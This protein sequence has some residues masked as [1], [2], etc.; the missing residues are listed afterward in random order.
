M[1]YP[2]YNDLEGYCHKLRTNPSNPLA[3]NIR[4]GEDDLEL[5]VRP[6]TRNQ[7]YDPSNVVDWRF[8]DPI[9]LPELSPFNMTKPTNNVAVAP[10]RRNL[11]TPT[12]N[13][14]D[15]IEEEADVNEGDDEIDME[16]QS[17]HTS[18]ETQSL[19]CQ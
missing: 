4:L 15:M 16:E 18:Q 19:S 17:N 12:P 14:D 13:D 7:K 8:I 9:E 1:I 11:P 6:H 10:G 3:T 5:R 2:R